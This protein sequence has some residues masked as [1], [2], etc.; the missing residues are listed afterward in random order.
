M[1]NLVER[2]RIDVAERQV[3]ELA[4]HFA[5][6][7]AVR[8][9]AIDLDGF[10]RDALAPVRLL[11][12]AER[13]HVVQPVRQFYDDDPDIVHHRQQHFAEALGLA[14]F[15]GEEI[16]LAQLGDAVHAARH[17]FAEVLAHVLDGDAG[18]LDHV[19][20]QPGLHAD[21]VHLHVGQEVGH[22]E[23]MHHV[24]VAGIADLQLVMFRG[25]TECLFELGEIV[26][27]PRFTRFGDELRK[28]LVYRRFRR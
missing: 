11:D 27:R 9:G 10:A 17:V 26:A 15:G 28:Q 21:Q 19:V 2:R 4:A 22:H 6:A 3:F 5:H 8:D 14:L 23:R 12:E 1:R 16:E 7:Q 13:A 24:G 25:E 20:Q 18:V